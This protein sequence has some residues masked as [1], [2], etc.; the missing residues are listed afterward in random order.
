MRNTLRLVL[1]AVCVSGAFCG[2]VWAW[3]PQAKQSIAM[4]AMQLVRTKYPEVF[5]PGE[6]PFEDAIVQG[7]KAGYAAL[8][9]R[10][11][12][13]TDSYAIQAVGSQMQLL[14]DIR[15]YGLDLYYAYRMGVLA[16]LVAD[17]SV[18]YGFAW[19]SQEAG[20]QE[21]INRDIEAH[22]ATFAFKPRQKT[23]EIIQDI[24]EYYSKQRLFFSDDK[25]IIADDY[26]KGVGYDGM[27]KKGGEAYFSR[28][29]EMVA[30]V[31]HTML[32]G[33]GPQH[34]TP[35]SARVLKWYFSDEITYLLANKK[36]N[37]AESKYADFASVQYQD[38]GIY[39]VLGDSYYAAEAADMVPHAL[40][41]WG[42][43]YKMAGDNRN[44][45]AEK[46]VRHYI[47]E[48][49]AC[50]DKASKPGA[51]D[52]DLLNA[53]NALDS[54]LRIDNGSAE[55]ADLIRE[56]KV[57]Q[58]ERQE[59]LLT[60]TNL[61]A[62]GQQG[63]ELGEKAEKTD[64]NDTNALLY[65]RDAIKWYKAVDDTFT[66]Q[67][68]TAKNAIS[69]LERRIKKIFTKTIDKATEAVENG[70]TALASNKHDD[71][72]N[73]YSSIDQILKVLPEDAPQD[74]LAQK[75]DLLGK[76]AANVDKAKTAKVEYEKAKKAQE[77]AAKRKGGGAAPPAAATGADTAM[78][79]GGAAPPPAAGKRGRRA[80]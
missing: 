45:V 9:G 39:E 35:A 53:L 64:L 69:D 16:S 3:G 66:A 57:K 30:D 19:N 11:S 80:D 2:P 70:D 61:I 42:S 23:L 8:E 59:H 78:T 24:Q 49:R 52:Q 38:P 13:S 73:S 4:T 36:F 58:K 40:R 12:L 65:Y 68:K 71:A 72:I 63:T 44:R 10:E 37:Q 41:E 51:E 46:L 75:T 15:P 76:M 32:V 7:A 6:T 56:A 48:G 77:E 18:P 21:K 27:L 28:S 34:E 22:I 55:I 54:A 79:G 26:S 25:Q 17:T 67:A 1:A 31:W 29:V 14:R 43:A 47:G 50:L 74:V 60:I 20:V 5:Q 33:R 62:Q